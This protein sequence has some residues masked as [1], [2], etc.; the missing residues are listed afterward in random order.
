MYMGKYE[1]NNSTDMCI[2]ACIL[3]WEPDDK[4]KPWKGH[5]K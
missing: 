4:L 1:S 3:F 2:E 5:N